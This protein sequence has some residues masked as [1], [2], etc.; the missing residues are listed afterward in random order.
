MASGVGLRHK[1]K[2]VGIPI[3]SLY[4]F[5]RQLV[6][7]LIGEDTRHELHNLGEF[8]S[9]LRTSRVDS[10]YRRGSRSLLGSLRWFS[11]RVIRDQASFFLV[12][13]HQSG[14]GDV[15]MP[16]NVLPTHHPT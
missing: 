8:F 1:R 14:S 3:V 6:V 5:L 4:S 13:D 7:S 9:S 11:P 2:G 15:S 12:R 10:L 16:K